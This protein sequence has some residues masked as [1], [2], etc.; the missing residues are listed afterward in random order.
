MFARAVLVTPS[1]L[2]AALLVAPL[3]PLLTSTSLVAP[4]LSSLSLLILPLLMST[5]LVL[6]PPLLV[7]VLP[8]LLGDLVHSVALAELAGVS[9]SVPALLAGSPVP[10]TLGLFVAPASPSVPVATGLPLR[11]AVLVGSA[12]SLLV[13]PVVR[14]P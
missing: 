13:L 11:A 9:A 5:L 4:L 3:L 6:A 14:L 8:S 10:L 1:L 7:L 2:V 12:G